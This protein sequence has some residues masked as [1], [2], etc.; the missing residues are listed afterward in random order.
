MNYYL[1]IDIGTTGVKSIIIDEKGICSAKNTENYELMT[2][3]PGWAEQNPE[4]WWKAVKVSVGKLLHESGIKGTEIKGIGLSGQMHGSVFLDENHSVIRPAILWCDQRTFEECDEITSKIGRENLIQHTCNPA[5]AGFTAPKILWLRNKEPEYYEKVRKILLPK[6]YVRFRLTGEFAAEVTD[7]SG[8]LLFDVK[9]RKWSDYMLSGLEI[10]RD[11]LP[12]CYE[13][14]EITG[15][16]SENASTETCLRAGTPVVGGAGDNAAGGIGNGVV[17]EGIISSILGTSGVLFAFAAKPELDPEGRL[18]TFCH[19]VPGKWHMTGVMLSAGG[20]FRWLR[21]ALCKSEV[22][23]ADLQQIDPYDVMAEKAGDAEPGSEGLIFLPYLTGERTPYS[24]PYARGV[25]FG[26]NLRH[27]K[28]HFI[29][30]V[31]EG[32]AYGMR[33]LLEI[34]RENNIAIKKIIASGGGGK[35]ALWRQIQADIF[36]YPM[37]TINNDEGS[38]FGVALLAAVGT[39]AY[40]TIEEACREAIQMTSETVPDRENIEMYDRYYTT[41]YHS[42]YTA[43]KEKFNDLAGIRKK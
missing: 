24:D 25:F 11:F 34:M 14:V 12:D 42:L 28:A 27:K 22:A 18:H 19:A 32:V 30:A 29:R 23:E 41:V 2:P 9:K 1:G 13:S 39:G 33:D 36:S 17:E 3:E 26:L 15:K 21:D 38:A 4:D 40:G 16:V 35:S 7:A 8:T 10:N 6:D 20:S 37:I 31:M 43:L 5:K